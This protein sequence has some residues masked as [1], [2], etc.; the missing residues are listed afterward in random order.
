[1]NI[2]IAITDEF[3]RKLERGEDYDLIDPHT[4]K[5]VESINSK[6]VFDLI[7][8]QAHKNGEP[9]I[10]FIDKMNDFNPTPKLG[11]YE[12]TNPCVTGDTFVSTEE[13]LVMIKDLAR[14]HAKGGIRVATDDRISSI[15][16]GD[17][18]EGGVAVKVKT[19]VSYFGI[20][21]AFKSGTKPIFR[22]TTDSGYE[23]MATAD[24]KIMTP[25]GWVEIKDLRAGVHKVLI[26]PAAG[27]FGSDPQ[28]EF[29]VT[30]EYKGKNGRFYSMNLPD[31][32]S[33]ELG[34]VL[35]WLLGDGWLRD[36]DKHCCVGFTFSQEDKEVLDYLKPIINRW[37]GVARDEILRDNNVYHLMY[38]RQHFVDFFKALGLK[39]TEDSSQKQVP[40]TLFWATEEA[41]K[42]FLQGLFTADGTI[43][44]LKDKNA[45]IR[46]TAKSRT[47]LKGVQLLLLQLGIKAKIYDFELSIS[48]DAVPL[49][50]EKV[51]F[52]CGRHN[53]KI[54]KLLSKDYYHAQFIEEIASIEACGEQEVF[55]LTEPQTHS[56]IANGIVIS[57]CGEQ[58]LLPYESCDLGSI[59]LSVI[60]R[61]NSGRYEINW[62]R[63]KEVTHLAVHFLDNLI[64]ENKFPLPQIEK[65]TKATRK[66]GLGVMGWASLLIKLNIP[67]N[68]DEAVALAEKVM[69][70]ILN[71]ATKKSLELGKSKGTFPAFKGSIYDKKEGPA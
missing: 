47:L 32:W 48:K 34:Q 45:Y 15:F 30:N 41:V 43:G 46:L 2:S 59:N 29:L 21:A 68:S 9:G 66:I 71:E 62:E 56:F 54:G 5:P 51:G 69:S 35:G 17:K 37:Y 49:F 22:L 36:G 44:F 38:N 27:R 55:D 52:L 39:T 19:G 61:N 26:Q 8:K 33:R 1:F 63:L 16:Y 3:M 12:S 18:E 64:D 23:L 60:C 20:S 24:H 40:E 70:F 67:Y 11:R 4:H 31:V 6:K 28:L 13:G 50:L 7:V 25:G 14:C 10:I 58:V 65:A 57:N 53:L 42:G